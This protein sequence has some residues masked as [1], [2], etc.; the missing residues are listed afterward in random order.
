MPH[1]QKSQQI[2][3]RGEHNKADVKR[4]LRPSFARDDLTGAFAGEENIKDGTGQ[5]ERHSTNVKSRKSVKSKT[6]TPI[7]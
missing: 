1:V 4:T 3:R 5:K 6:R 7:I 2:K